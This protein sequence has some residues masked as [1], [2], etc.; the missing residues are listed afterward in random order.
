M[1]ETIT[2][3]VIIFL[4]GKGCTAPE[5]Q[6]VR[7]VL[8][9]GVGHII[10]LNGERVNNLCSTVLLDRFRD[11]SYVKLLNRRKHRALMK[12]K[13]AGY[14]FHRF[15]YRLHVPDVVAINTSKQFRSGGPLK[16]HY[17]YSV[18]QRGGYPVKHWEPEELKC[19]HHAR[20]IYHGIFNPIPGY[21]QG[22]IVTNEQLVAYNGI[23]VCGELAIYSWNIGHG[24]HLAN[25][26]MTHLT[27]ET[28]LYLLAN[29]PGVKYFVMGNWSD[30]LGIGTGLQDFKRE[31]LF[32]PVYLIREV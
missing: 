20:G 4:T 32:E 25:G 10:G 13:N 5:C 24:E 26:V 23:S 27:V 30:G 11:G 16:E 15:N 7:D 19:N 3:P 28:V 14:T 21:K 22:E 8:F 12:S 9:N 29:H 17:K 18:E 2:Y 6:G 31:C 1:S